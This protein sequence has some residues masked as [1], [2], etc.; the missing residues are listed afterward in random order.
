[1]KKDVDTNQRGCTSQSG[2][3][4]IPIVVIDTETKPKIQRVPRMFRGVEA[5]QN[6]Y[7]PLV[8]SIGPFHHSKELEIMEEHKCT[9][10]HQYAE[11]AGQSYDLLYNKVKAIAGAARNCFSLDSSPE[12]VLDEEKFT[13]MM[14][15][16]G[17]FILQFI[18]CF[19]NDY[20]DLNMKLCLAAFVKR[21]LLLLENQLPFL[22]LRELMSSKEDEWKK[23]FST[24]FTG[25]LVLHSDS[26]RKIDF[27][28]CTHLLDMI[29]TL[30]IDKDALSAPKY[31]RKS[32]S[33]DWFSC[34]S[35]KELNAAGIHFRPSQEGEKR[36]RRRFENRESGGSRPERAAAEREERTGGGGVIRHGGGSI[37]GFD[38]M[39]WVIWGW[40][41]VSADKGAREDNLGEIACAQ[42]NG[43]VKLESTG[44]KE[45]IKSSVQVGSEVCTPKPMMILQKGVIGSK[46]QQ[47]ARKI[48]NMIKNPSALK[49]KN[50]LPSSETKWIG[51]RE[52]V[53]AA[54]SGTG[55]SGSRRLWELQDQELEEWGAGGCASCRTGGGIGER[56]GVGAT[57]SGT[58]GSGSGRVWELQN[59]RIEEREGVGAAGSGTG[60]SGSGRVWKLQDQEFED[61][62]AGGCGSCR[63]R[64]WWIGEREG[65]EVVGSGIGGSGSRRLWELQDQEL[66]VGSGSGRVWEL[67]NWRIGEWEG[68]EAAG[69]GIGGS[70]SG[71]VL[72][73]QDQ[74]LVDRVAGGCGSCKI[75]NWRRALR[76]CSLVCLRLLVYMPC[77]LAT[78][79][80]LVIGKREVVGAAGSGT[81]G[82]GSGRV[83]KLQDKELQDRVAGGCGSCRIRNWRIG[84]R[85]GVEAAG[86]GIGGGTGLQEVVGAAGS[87][88]GGSGNGR[89]WELQNWRWDRSGGR[90][91]RRIGIGGSGNGRVWELQNWRIG[92]QEF[93]GAAGSGTGGSGSGRVWE[94]QNWRIGEREG[95]GATGSRTG[96]G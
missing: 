89:V 4:E 79:C 22:V 25:I 29:H 69:S 5:N 40:V 6:C 43:S 15:H 28:K 68:V 56:E 53:E 65:V 30:L 44:D 70:G 91:S 36:E 2:D 84:E 45:K 73:L 10:T 24:F 54:G 96:G 50:W 59:W 66:E 23:T 33:T 76:A 77:L 3:T 39:V 16:D 82:S 12:V 35:A 64:N 87:A 7:D 19:V 1:M 47:T 51:E 11:Y 20:K 21:D 37:S 71:R 60:G 52:V 93:V 80:D 32:G 74:E 8:V 61:R 17:C 72:E 34:R 18:Q 41:I 27:D 86:S 90:G 13:K 62:V 38:S 81:G 67:Q 9:M 49:P 31:N 88:T 57:E 95:V 94:L 14:F 85:E 55:G 78:V 75:S 83:L 58:G 26:L 63:I 48:A 92:L 42:V 46:K